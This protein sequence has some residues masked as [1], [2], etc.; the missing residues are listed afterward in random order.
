MQR[1]HFGLARE[2]VLQPAFGLQRI[3][4]PAQVDQTGL[5]VGIGR[6]EREGTQVQR[7]RLRALA[8]GDGE[9]GETEQGVEVVRVAMHDL[10]VVATGVFMSTFLPG[11][12]RACQRRIEARH[13]AARL[14]TDFAAGHAA[15][16]GRGRR[17]RRYGLRRRRTARRRVRPRGGLCR[18]LGR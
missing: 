5:H 17:D 6:V 15:A 18:K 2:Q 8:A 4:F 14:E 12:E 13:V 1:G 16:G 9:G 11:R 10:L 3:A 7:F